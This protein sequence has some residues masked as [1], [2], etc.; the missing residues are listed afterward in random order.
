M[1]MRTLVRVVAV[2]PLQGMALRVR[3]SD[4]VER[5]LDL[6]PMLTS[7]VFESLRDPAVFAA[8]AV[9]R[10]AGTVMWP[11]AIDLD[12]DVLHGDA[13]PMH[14]PGPRLIAERRTAG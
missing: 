2:E 1:A 8:V 10:I 13:T 12:P 11:N 4:G 5:D 6:E 9:D 7:G 14:G 3:F